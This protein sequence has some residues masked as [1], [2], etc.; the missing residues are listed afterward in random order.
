MWH[1]HHVA[2]NRMLPTDDLTAMSLV[3]RRA[4]ALGAL[5]ILLLAACGGDD[6]SADHHDSTGSTIA[7]S[8]SADA[9][10]IDVDADAAEPTTQTVAKGSTVSLHITAAEEHEFHVHGYDI[11]SEG[12]D[13]TITFVADEAGEFE[14]ETHDTEQVVFTL[15]VE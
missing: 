5:P 9:I 12:T 11:E 1:S 10:V 6:E 15:V 4:L 13:V 3:L 14:V 8:A 2:G 7:A